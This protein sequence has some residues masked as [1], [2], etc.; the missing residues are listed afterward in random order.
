[1]SEMIDHA[2][3]YSEKGWQVFPLAPKEKKPMKGT[4]GFLDAGTN[5]RILN[6]YW[7]STPDAN[8]GIA[9]GKATGYFV[10]DIDGEDGS[11]SL[12]D[13]ENEIGPLP[14]TM[15]QK[16][17]SGGRHLL[18]NWPG[19][20]VRNKQNLRK[21][22][23]IR[24]EG[25][26]I[27]A[28][29]SI[30]P[31]G[32]AYSWTEDN[33]ELANIPPAWLDFIAP[34]KK[35]LAPW[36]SVTKK[37][38]AKPVARVPSGQMS[39]VDRARLYLSKCEPA[40][41][42]AG[43]HNKL[44]WAAKALVVGLQLDDNTAIELLW[45]NFNPICSP[46]WDRGNAADRRDFERKVTEARTM[47]SDKKP[48]WLLDELNLRSG[49]DALAEIATGKTMANNLIRSAEAQNLD[50][51]EM[52][53]KHTEF[54]AEHFPAELKKY[55][56]QVSEAHVVD[57][58]FVGLPM[59]IV[60]SAAM[61]NV[62]RLRLKKGFVVPPTLWGGI[63]ANSGTNKSGP[64]REIIEPL[65]KVLTASDIGTSLL[66]PQSDLVVSNATLEAIISRLNE[67][68]RGLI[69]F[70]DE[71]AGWV[72]SFDAYKKSS[73]DEQAWLEFW[74]AKE[75][76]LDRKTNN[77]RVKIP[78]AS[79]CVL[80]GIQPQKLVECFDPGKFA[81]GLVPR[82]LI[83]SPPEQ[84][85]FWSENEVEGALCDEWDKAITNLRAREFAAFD[86]NQNEYTPFILD[87]SPEA[88]KVYVKF[89]NKMSKRLHDSED[90]HAKSFMS[91]SRVNA[92]RLI[93]VHRGM[94]LATD[95][96]KVKTDPVGVESAIAGCAWAEWCLNEQMRVYGYSAIEYA[97]E[98]AH[99]LAGRIAMK[100]KNKKA[101]ARTVMA[102]NNR[103]FTTMKL[104]H[105]GLES[106]VSAGYARWL[107]TTEIELVGDVK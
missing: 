67:S 92:G 6:R 84:S 62:W 28:A 20:E 39:V 36:E 77:E 1:M 73:G 35:N 81:S 107:S 101:T 17:G 13:L 90:E 42:G 57:V 88:K 104:A 34:L 23:D 33:N 85:M 63:V 47:Q 70:R 10:V 45:S 48:G 44:L 26:Y 51:T 56:Y 14:D 8:I 99:Y 75:Y 66:C 103:K 74:D 4:N 46:Q 53:L 55:C 61:G 43:G 41:Q 58:S 54:P 52:S 5:E 59:L 76:K 60:T 18:F 102:I 95:N 78:S 16:T 50:V 40:V 12:T 87:L 91:K 105:K 86:A 27:V 94:V 30:H 19:R 2:L 83:T 98:Q 79:V 31:N 65:K 22:I 100:C 32:Q 97:R 24:G 89:F 15:E 64:L 96:T 69:A 11:R 49:A 37:A 38:D 25:G 82:L 7:D 29:P 68:P 106:L 80:G 21:G 93:L 9:T 71:L 3:E 72:N